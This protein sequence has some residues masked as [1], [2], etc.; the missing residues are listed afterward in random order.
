MNITPVEDVTTVTHQKVG[1]N[2]IRGRLSI[3]QAVCERETF[4]GGGGGGGGVINN[5]A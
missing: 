1:L 5:F 2:K 4:T 3:V